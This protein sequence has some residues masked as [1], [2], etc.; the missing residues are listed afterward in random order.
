M[1]KLLL[2]I[3][4][5]ALSSP[6]MALDINKGQLVNVWLAITERDSA[7]FT[8]GTGAF[9]V[10]TR[11]GTVIQSSAG[12]TVNNT[13]HYIYGLIDTTAAAFVDD[14]YCQVKFTFAVSTETY[15]YYVPIHIFTYILG[16]GE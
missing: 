8:I 4:L 14:L 10:Q 1:K 15:V 5:F 16:S 7:A 13:T 2:I 6:V 11:D 12:A 3:M 9:E